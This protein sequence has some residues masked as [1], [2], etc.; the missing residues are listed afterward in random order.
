LTV[1]REEL[2]RRTAARVGQMWDAGLVDE[3]RALADRGLREGRTAPRAVGYAQVLAA[4]DGVTTLDEAREHTAQATR[5]LIRRQE[6]WFRR[7]ARIV[8]LDAGAEDL[9]D[10]ALRAV[11]GARG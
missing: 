4:L 11:A 8:W 5:R 10:R 1:P 3:V 2:D 7:D 6:S 9:A